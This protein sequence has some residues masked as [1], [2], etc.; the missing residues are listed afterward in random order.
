MRATAGRGPLLPFCF[1]VPCEVR[2][3]AWNVKKTV[4]SGESARRITV[5]ADAAPSSGVRA[6]NAE[7]EVPSNHRIPRLCGRATTSLSAASTLGQEKKATI[8]T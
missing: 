1:D 2:N 4:P 8:S 6:S 7:A 5:P 3:T